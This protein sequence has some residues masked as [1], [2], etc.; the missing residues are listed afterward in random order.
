MQSILIALLLLSSCANALH[1]I[2]HEVN[3]TIKYKAEKVDYW[4]TAEET[5]ELKTGDCEDF[6]VL[7][8]KKMVD[9]GVLE[10]SISFLIVQINNSD[11]YHAMIKVDGKYYDSYLK[12]RGVKDNDFKLIEEFNINGVIKSNTNTSY[13]PKFIKAIR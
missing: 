9:S 10:T 8:Y 3:Y 1:K 11:S 7:K 6:A 13:Y 5:A 4:Q 2:D 12:A